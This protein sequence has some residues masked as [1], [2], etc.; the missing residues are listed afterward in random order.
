MK[1]FLIINI[2]QLFKE[3]RNKSFFLIIKLS[4][5]GFLLNPLKVVLKRLNI[6]V[7]FYLLV[8]CKGEAIRGKE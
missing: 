3:K 6:L 7:P 8:K 2:G 1:V 4:R 5:E